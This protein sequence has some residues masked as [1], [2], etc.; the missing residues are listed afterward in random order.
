MRLVVGLGNI[1]KE[2]KLT[3]HN[4]GFI[5]LDRFAEK[6]D[7]S[8]SRT[9]LYLYFKHKDCVFIKPKTY[10]N[11]SGEAYLSVRA[12]WGAFEDILAVVDDVDLPTGS[13][14]IRTGGG[15]GGHNGL[16]SLIEKIGNENFCRI[17]I[18]IGKSIETT[19]TNYVLE[20]FSNDELIDIESAADNVCG[21]LDIY[22]ELGINKFLDEYSKWTKNS[23]P[24]EKNGII[25]PK[26]EKNDKGL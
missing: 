26:E 24:S 4:V 1:G 2:Y 19:T 3:R 16:K 21:W 7:K 25:R 9:G 10:M 20:K 23:I 6:H 18:G 14:R 12:K 11:R 13:I 22:S 15:D 17:R 5:C 8:Y